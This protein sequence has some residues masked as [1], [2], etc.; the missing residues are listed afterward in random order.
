[1]ARL[2]QR[3]PLEV[4][5]EL[6]SIVDIIDD[7]GIMCDALAESPR[8]LPSCTLRLFSLICDNAKLKLEVLESKKF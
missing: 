8:D 1:M 4:R 5:D 2:P 3:L 6:N 7:L